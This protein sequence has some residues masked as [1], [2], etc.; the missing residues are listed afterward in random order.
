MKLFEYLKKLSETPED[1]REEFLGYLEM[2][3]LASAEL[4][5]TDMWILTNAANN[6]EYLNSKLEEE[7]LVPAP[8]APDEVTAPTVEDEIN[9]AT[10]DETAVAPTDTAEVVPTEE[11]P[12][13]EVPATEETPTEETPTEETEE[14]DDST[15]ET[16]KEGIGVLALLGEIQEKLATGKPS[17]VEVAAIKALKK[18]VS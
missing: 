6:N 1:K 18:L 11:T 2:R 4:T 16:S 14:E 13:E 17:P 3:N 10:P 5:E 8:E 9:S 15:I 12:T 7:D